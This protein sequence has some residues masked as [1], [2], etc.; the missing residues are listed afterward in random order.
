M[1][2][3]LTWSLLFNEVIELK[4]NINTN[5]SGPPVISKL[6]MALHFLYIIKRY[7]VRHNRCKRNLFL[8]NFYV[9]VILAQFCKKVECQKVKFHKGIFWYQW[10]LIYLKAYLK[11]FL[12]WNQFKFKEL[13]SNSIDYLTW[14]CWGKC[15]KM[16][17]NKTNAI[18]NSLCVLNPGVADFVRKGIEPSQLLYLQKKKG[19]KVVQRKLAASSGEKSE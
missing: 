16:L 6:C 17:P 18:K 7:S 15:C 4:T 12:C 10:H 14:R 11:G 19:G 1:K 13:F 3:I 9:T 2:G 8:L 5:V